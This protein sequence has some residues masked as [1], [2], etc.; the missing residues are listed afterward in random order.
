M[1]LVITHD[2]LLSLSRVHV[3]V[4]YWVHIWVQ[5]FGVPYLRRLMLSMYEITDVFY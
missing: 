5:N 2:F 1:K 4:L 3:H